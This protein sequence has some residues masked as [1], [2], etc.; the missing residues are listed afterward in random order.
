MI[1]YRLSPWVDIDSG[2]PCFGLQAQ[3]DKG[4]P[5]IHCCVTPPGERKRAAVYSDADHAKALVKS[6]NAGEDP[7]L[8]PG[9][10]PLVKLASWA[11][12]V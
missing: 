4:K 11:T 5:Y 3:T 10:V 6:L 7:D 9:L 8:I 2:A 12:K 1:T